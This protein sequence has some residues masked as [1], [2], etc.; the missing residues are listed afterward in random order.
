VIA[1]SKIFHGF[2]QQLPTTLGVDQLATLPLLHLENQGRG[3]PDWPEF[4]S[5]ANAKKTK[6][7]PG[8]VFTTYGVCLQMATLGEGLALS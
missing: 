6:L 1:F 2:A 5:Y 7:E 8:L 4:L 3:W